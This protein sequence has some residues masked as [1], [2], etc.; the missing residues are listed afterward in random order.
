ML[1]IPLEITRRNHGYSICIDEYKGN[2]L[3]QEI[4]SR[5]PA[6]SFIAVVDSNVA[7]RYFPDP[8]KSFP[9]GWRVYQVKAG[10]EHKT[11]TDFIALVESILRDGI[12]RK[13]VIVAVGGGVVGDLAGFAAATLLRGV[14][15]VQVPTT[16]LAQVDSSVGGKTGINMSG[17]KNLLGAFYQP[18]LVVID[19]AFLS[20][21]SP[22]EYLSGLAEVVKYGVIGDR[23]FFDTLIRQAEEICKRDANTLAGIVAHCCRMKAD[24]VGS[25]EKESAQRQLLNLGHTFGHALE[26]LA[27]YD[28]TLLHG[29]SVSIG[30]VMAAWFAVEDRSMSPEDAEEMEDGFA[31]LGLPRGLG[32]I[33]LTLE[34]RAVIANSIR[35]EQ[36]VAALGMDKK[37]ASGG[38]TLI[39]PTAIGACRIDKNVSADQVAEH[40]RVQCRN[41]L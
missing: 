17:G 27:G 15:L 24:I 28:G 11:S 34:K 14:R 3:F 4:E 36:L 6:S 9:E 19:P 33:D 35:S 40:I 23:N 18:E 31:S 39:L 10:E 20:T 8:K 7:S 26:A 1:E 21:L 30:T 2:R 32:D 12:D 22:R 5:V 16:L 41:I 38:L 37:A 25:D 29:E 13:T